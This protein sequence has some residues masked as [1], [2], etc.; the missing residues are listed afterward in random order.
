[1]INKILR[2]ILRPARLRVHRVTWPPPVQE[3][4]LHLEHLSEYLKYL[5]LS[6]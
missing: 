5:G 3:T 4:H 1:M 2:K 6:A